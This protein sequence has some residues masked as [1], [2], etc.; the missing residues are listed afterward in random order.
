MALTT[1]DTDFEEEADIKEYLLD[2][3][4]EIVIAEK[5]GGG[6][7]FAFYAIHEGNLV[8]MGTTPIGTADNVT[9]ADG[10]WKTTVSD[11]P[12]ADL[13]ETVARRGGEEYAGMVL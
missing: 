4:N 6:V 3:P 13:A 11:D 8:L 2:N 10:G 12:A 7:R 9:L 5:P 1:A